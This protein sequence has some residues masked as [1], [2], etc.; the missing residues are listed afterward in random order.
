VITPMRNR[1]VGS[2]MVMAVWMFSSLARAQ[3]AP[4]HIDGWGRPVPEPPKGQ[5]AAPAPR[6]DLSGIW[7]PAAGWRDG[8]QANGPRENP[9]DGKHTLPFTP[10]G[11]KEFKAHKPGFGTTA[12]PIAFNNDPFNIC[13]PLGFPRLD[14]FNLRALQIVQTQ[15][16]VLILYQNSQVWRNI[17]MDGR[18][19]PKDMDTMERRWYGYSVGKWEDDTTFVVET[20]G[21][22]E[23]TWIDNVGRPHSSDL[24]VEER[25]HR[26]DNDIIEL[27]VTINDPKMYTK[28][29]LALDKFRLRLQPP[30][31]DI[32]EMICSASE[33]A[34]YN[35]QISVQTG[36]GLPK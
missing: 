5:K 2:T 27:T 4:V 10:L 21:L 15:R 34:D 36:A 11:E 7:E 32:R 26:V 22:D 33:A 29:W 35:K 3:T 8:V 20:A 31:F 12:V 6:R 18:E 28:P 25:Y 24:R 16:Q 19:L 30:G 9:S 14:L 17:W 23:R 13:D 1:F